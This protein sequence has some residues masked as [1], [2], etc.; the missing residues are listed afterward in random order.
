MLTKWLRIR[1]AVIFDSSARP[2]MSTS[3]Q[4]ARPASDISWMT[5]A[6]RPTLRIPPRGVFG[7]G[8]RA[9]VRVTTKEIFSR[10][11]SAR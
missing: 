1:C 5:I 4:P 9:V 2:T 6:A 7:I 10:S 11:T 8:G 3:R